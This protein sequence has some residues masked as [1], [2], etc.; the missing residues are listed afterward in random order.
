MTQQLKCESPFPAKLLGA[1]DFPNLLDNLGYLNLDDP[2][3]SLDKTLVIESTNMLNGFFN[4]LRNAKGPVNYPLSLFREEYPQLAERLDKGQILIAEVAEFANNY[5]VNIPLTAMPAPG[6]TPNQQ[7]KSLLDKLDTFYTQNLGQSLSG[8]FC[9][10]FTNIF[11]KINALIAIVNTVV[12]FINDLKNFDPEAFL[13]GL[14]NSIMGPLVQIAKAIKATIEALAAKFLAIADQ[15]AQSIE[16]LAE[17]LKEA[18]TRIANKIKQAVNSV[19]EFF[20]EDNQKSLGDYIE[21]IITSASSAFEKIDPFIIGLLMYRFCQLTNAIQAFMESPIKGLQTA[22]NGII[23]SQL[24]AQNIAQVNR[25]RAVAAGANRMDRDEAE[26]ARRRAVERIN[27]DAP[28]PLFIYVQAQENRSRW[29]GNF[30][31]LN[32]I[33]TVRLRSYAYLETMTQAEGQIIR[34]LGTNNNSNGS[35]GK[36]VFAGNIRSVTVRAD[37]VNTNNPGPGWTEVHSDT[38]HRALRT[39]EQL[40]GPMIILEGFNPGIEIL[41][42]G[43]A[44]K[45]QA[46]T[47]SDI[48][49]LIVAASRAR[50]KGIIVESD[51]VVLIN[52]GRIVAE[53]RKGQGDT[54]IYGNAL[55]LHRQQLLYKDIPALSLNPRDTL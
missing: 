26:A 20:S 1:G 2:V 45:V 31:D 21:E 48:T 33:R 38:W 12:G 18:G 23:K 28:T 32:W 49:Q 50:F 29:A 39:Q 15:I 52:S 4:G 6:A 3:Q 42:N 10:A 54:S 40:T 7:Q 44:I 53:D 36:I 16:N 30:Q 55:E 13:I 14:F 8:G 34:D 22:V 43:N 47:D 5:K 35:P 46:V 9:A 19:K 51:G 41:S 17:D 37:G 27:D 25:Q 11:E 24:I